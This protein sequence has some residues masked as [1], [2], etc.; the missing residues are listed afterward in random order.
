MPQSNRLGTGRIPFWDPKNEGYLWRDVRAASPR[1]LTIDGEISPSTLP[2]QYYWDSGWWGYQNG[3]PACVGFSL[4]HYLAD[5]PITQ[6]KRPAIDPMLMYQLAQGVDRA[7][8][9]NYD[10][11]ATM[12][13]GAKAAQ[14]QGFFGEYRWILTLAEMIDVVYNVAPLWMGTIWTPSMFETDK[15]GILKTGRVASAN[16][17]GHA[18]VINGVHTTRA[19]FRL[20]NSWSRTW[21]HNGHAYLSFEDAEWLLAQDGEAILPRELR[22]VA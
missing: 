9:R 15:D 7:E 22:K 19:F 11:G 3:F 1:A 10:S 18:W 2:Y 14:A 13:A 21:G 20:K 12:L 6:A 5:G 8:G 16:D 4:T 17:D